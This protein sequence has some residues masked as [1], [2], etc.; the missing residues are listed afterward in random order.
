MTKHLLNGGLA[1]AALIGLAA[2][3]TGAQ[4]MPGAPSFT[5]APQQE[6]GFVNVANRR[7]PYNNVNRRND[8][9]NDTGDAQVE[10][11]NQQSLQRAQQGMNSP[12]P[13]PDTT[14][15]LNDMSERSAAGG[16]NMGRRAPMPFR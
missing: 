15:N 13:G 2:V 9:G 6:S 4:A 1:M 16:R 7:R 8:A 14:G 10:A 3:P 5:A 11:L 12:T